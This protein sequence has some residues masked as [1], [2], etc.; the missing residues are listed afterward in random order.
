M[1]PYE[2]VYI[3]GVWDG[4]SLAM[5]SYPLYRNNDLMLWTVLQ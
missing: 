5:I 2:D 4:G 1:G 3:I